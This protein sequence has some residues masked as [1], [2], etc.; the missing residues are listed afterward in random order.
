M[1][2]GRVRNQIDLPKALDVARDKRDRGI[3]YATIE[4]RNVTKYLL[5]AESQ[6][7]T[8]RLYKRGR[9]A[10]HRASAPGEL[11][12]PDFGIL[13]N[14]TNFEIFSGP[15][16]NYGQVGVFAEYAAALELGTERMAARPFLSL[17]PTAY[18]ERVRKAFAVGAELS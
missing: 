13:R 9:N 12:S 7:R 4:A 14:S 1:I 11:P 5:S 15:G 2:R 6:T 16:G 3:L 10:Y 8:G 18:G 17:V